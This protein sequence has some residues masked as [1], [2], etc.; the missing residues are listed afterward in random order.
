MVFLITIPAV[1]FAVFSVLGYGYTIHRKMTTV[2]KSPAGGLSFSGT[3]ALSGYIFWGIGSSLQANF[4]PPWAS[5]SV[6]AVGFV[7]GLSLL[8]FSRFAL[9]NNTT[10]GVWGWLTYFFIFLSMGYSITV[11]FIYNFGANWGL[12]VDATA[13]SYV[14]PNVF[15]VVGGS[16]WFIGIVFCGLFLGPLRDMFKQGEGVSAYARSED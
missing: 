9:K 13:R 1:F 7:Y 11:S 3:L 6:L 14:F 5:S 10:P 4:W 2:K 15:V 8:C 12:V 16:L